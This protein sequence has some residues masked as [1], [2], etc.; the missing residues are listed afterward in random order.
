MSL[1]G[2]NLGN[3]ICQDK[4]FSLKKQFPLKWSEFLVKFSKLDFVIFVLIF[5]ILTLINSLL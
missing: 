2:L 1:K 5:W 3:W 4:S